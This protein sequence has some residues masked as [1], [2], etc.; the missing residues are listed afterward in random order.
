MVNR[1]EE[2]DYSYIEA[3]KE[4]ENTTEKECF[5]AGLEKSFKYNYK[6]NICY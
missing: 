2:V 5:D 6:I 1:V 3:I 4:V